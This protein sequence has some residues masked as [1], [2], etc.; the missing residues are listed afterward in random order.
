MFHVRSLRPCR[1]VEGIKAW[2]A[3]NSEVETILHPS[4]KAF[5]IEAR[6]PTKIVAVKIT[7]CLFTS[8]WTPPKM[9]VVPCSEK[10]CQVIQFVTFIYIPDRW[11]SLNHHVFTIPK[12][13]RIESPGDCD[14]IIFKWR[15]LFTGI[16][17]LTQ[18][19]SQQKRHAYYV[20]L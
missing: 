1:L 10:H 4:W 2:S 13:S 15:C 17:K 5:S 20:Y 6:L 12:R 14:F 8:C 3:V 7:N 18:K 11:R 9:L 16:P 19:E